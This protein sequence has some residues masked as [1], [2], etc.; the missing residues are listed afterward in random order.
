MWTKFEQIG[1]SWFWNRLCSAFKFALCNA[2]V[3]SSGVF[4][5]KLNPVRAEIMRNRNSFYPALLIFWWVWLQGVS[6]PLSIFNNNSEF[7]TAHRDAFVSQTVEGA[8]TSALCL[9]WLTFVLWC[10][11]RGG[12]WSLA[13]QESHAHLQ[14]D[15][16]K[17]I[18]RGRRSHGVGCVIR[19]LPP[20]MPAFLCDSFFFF[21]MISPSIPGLV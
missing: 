21:Y 16:V 8:C 14:V 19:F 5:W 13:W 6:V 3:S 10:S 20:N 1:T 11:K 12:R 7:G 18:F 4:D 15:R 17:L 2:S 9:Q